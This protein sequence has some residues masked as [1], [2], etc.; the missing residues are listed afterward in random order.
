MK[1]LSRVSV[2]RAQL[3]VRFSGRSNWMKL[4]QRYFCVICRIKWRSKMASARWLSVTFSPWLN[5]TSSRW[6]KMT[7]ALWWNFDLNVGP[8]WHLSYFL[9]NFLVLY[10]F[11][12]SWLSIF[13]CRLECK[14]VFKEY[15]RQML[16]RTLLNVEECTN[17][18]T[19]K[20]V[21]F[22]TI[23]KDIRVRHIYSYVYQLKY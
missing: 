19:I 3:F 23:N 12:I 4:V 9:Y 10:F 2:C 7:F 5:V 1:T 17:I 22:L 14:W 21:Q 15:I 20:S 13:F 6:S 8:M 18:L 11:N 16:T